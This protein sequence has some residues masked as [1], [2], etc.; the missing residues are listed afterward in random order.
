MLTHLLKE[1]AGEVSRNSN[2]L[3]LTAK[4]DVMNLKML[5]TGSDFQ[6][7]DRP[8]RPASDHLIKGFSKLCTSFSEK[9][10]AETSKYR[11]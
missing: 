8:G 11:N 3:W 2:L 6:N 7:A 1:L 4:I 10:N 9:L 5:M